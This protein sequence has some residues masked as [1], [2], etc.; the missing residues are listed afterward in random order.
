MSVTSA[1]FALAV[2][3][4]QGYYTPQEARQLFAEGAEAYEREQY[5]RAIEAWA[6]LV[7]RGPDGPDVLYNLGTAYLRKGD[8][9]HAVL[10]LER[11]RRAMPGSE[12][13]RANLE[14]ARARQLDRV[15]G[16][17]G[18]PFVQRLAAAFP[19]DAESWIFLGAWGG[20]F[21]ALIALRVARRRRTALA[22]AAGALLLVAV[23]SGLLVGLQAYVARTV[24]EAVVMTPALQARELP[25]AN[26]RVAFEVHAGLKVR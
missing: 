14:V 3:L 2:V 12:D 1:S 18:E 17:D 16:G 11:A 25:A 7:D 9:G 15:V 10:Y 5:E 22:L 23:P 6:R 8:L 26:A 13:V 4:A 24:R 20:T 21:A 19:A